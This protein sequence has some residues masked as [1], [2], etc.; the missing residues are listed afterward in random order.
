MPLIDLLIYGN[1]QIWLVCTRN[2]GYFLGFISNS[3]WCIFFIYIYII[4]NDVDT[5]LSVFY[6]IVKP[7]HDMFKNCAFW[8]EHYA[9]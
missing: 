9:I 1:L 8:G 7:D 6:S 5:S 2:E 3:Y 4:V